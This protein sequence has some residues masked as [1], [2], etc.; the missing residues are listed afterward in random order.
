ML[1][2][3]RK[4]LILTVPSPYLAVTF[5][6]I[7][8]GSGKKRDILQEF[9]SASGTLFNEFCCCFFMK[10]SIQIVLNINNHN[11]CMWLNINNYNDCMI[12]PK[13]QWR[14]RPRVQDVDGLLGAH[15]HS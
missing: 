3:P 13:P 5:S 7:R 14:V 8:G 11:D 4:P 2:V 12:V 1:F 15:W 9:A 10:E 6:Q